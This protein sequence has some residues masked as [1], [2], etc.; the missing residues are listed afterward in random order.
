MLYS[1]NTLKPTI[2][3]LLSLLIFFKSEAQNFGKPSKEEI[4]MTTYPEDPEA[5]GVVLYEKGTY[6][7]EVVNNYLRLIKEI[8][9]K[10]KVLNAKKFEQATVEIPYY[11]TPDTREKI[12]KLSAV[13]I[14]GKIPNFVSDNA[15]FDTDETENWSLKKFTFPNVQDGSILEYTYRI[16]SP[17]FFNL[18]S[19]NFQGPL[20][21]IYSEFQ[22]DIPGNWQYN[23]TLLGNRK[24]N[25]NRVELKKN[26]FHLRD[27]SA[28]ADC[29]SATY[30][31]ENVPALKK[32]RYMLSEK[33]YISRIKYELINYTN[34][35]GKKTSYTGTW[36]DTDKVFKL[37][38]S[39][40]QQLKYDSYFKKQIPEAILSIGNDLERA[41]AVY[42]F[43]QDKMNW[44]G[45][46]WLF[47]NINVK[48][49]FEQRKGNSS[50]INLGLINALKAAGLEAKIMLIA[51]RN[52]ELPTRHYPVLTDFNYAMV[53][54]T[55]N[56]EKY[57]LD[58]T[59]KYTP[60]G[61]I[62]F[63]NL[64]VEGRVLDFDKGS[65]WEPIEPISKN[66]HYVNMKLAA[67]ENGEFTGDIN[68]VSTGYIS[69]EKRKEYNNYSREETLKRKQG[70]NEFLD[71]SEY[72]I[73]NEKELEQPFKENYKIKIYDQ[74]VAN[75]LFLFPFL[76]ETYFS[77]NPFI[78][79]SRHYPIHLGFPLENNYLIAI[80]LNG[81][82]KLTQLPQNKILKLPNNNGEF[83]V[84]YAASGNTINIRLNVKLNSYS[85][86]PEAYQTLQQYFASLIKT[87]TG[88]PI[89]L[90]KI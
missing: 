78:S 8:Y 35:N 43:F 70:K 6:S 48:D 84:V 18:G 37:D 57:F 39:L 77:E 33:N 47:S 46:Y 13:T 88:E 83:S 42:Y 55:I 14:N 61:I 27:Y 74:S 50:E 62:P 67:N 34:F 85:F 56:N 44:N 24:L 68:E 72:K 54:L 12:T 45:K 2:F 10:T 75:K 3:L 80:D 26:C 23:R 76:M 73:E 40:G 17:Y 16:E 81:H 66:L 89:E 49:A 90:E 19:W 86:P 79:S 9:V 30:V 60:F 69:V 20:P 29:E 22:T 25:V 11:R 28:Q 31:M 1:K 32:E 58:A 51:T 38:K 63:R 87:Q 64:N 52:F 53:F 7:V 59:E 15:I 82:Y 36:E 4:S 21:V 41:K 5:A 65:Y 71:I